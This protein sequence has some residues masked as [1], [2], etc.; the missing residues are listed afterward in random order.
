[1]STE[2]PSFDGARQELFYQLSAY[3]FLRV[4]GPCRIPEN[5]RQNEAITFFHG[6]A[7]Q[8]PPPGSAEETQAARSKVWF[9]KLS[10]QLAS[11]TARFGPLV[12]HTHPD[13]IPDAGDVLMGKVVPNDRPSDG[14][15]RDRL[16]VFYT[17]VNHLHRL[18]HIVVNGTSVSELALAHE[19]RVRRPVNKGVDDAWALARLILFGNVQV[20]ADQ[21]RRMLPE[22]Q[23]M[24]LSTDALTF[25]HDT[26][27]HL[28]DTS[29]WEAFVRLV[30]DAQPPTPRT[31]PPPPQPV[32]RPLHLTQ[33]QSHNYN[34][35]YDGGDNSFVGK[36]RK[37]TSSATT[38]AYMPV[39]PPYNPPLP[40]SPP[41][42]LPLSPPQ[43]PPYAPQS[44]PYVDDDEYDPCNP[45]YQYTAPVPTMQTP[46]TI[47]SVLSLLQAVNQVQNRNAGVIAD[48][49]NQ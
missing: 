39:S 33:P 29:V 35:G 17:H 49:V 14:R 21:H 47:E 9:K 12:V 30:P 7:I 23:Q 42:P 25:V 41:P 44:P 11:R 18:L 26:S 32:V 48:A 31:P 5:A 6:T 36:R 24:K 2:A 37:C 19:L 27:V 10:C 46:Y 45:E 4:V 28:E 3:Q 8:L 16:Q 43:S 22:R 15:D 1:M 13:V 34:H 38:P 40:L 20:F